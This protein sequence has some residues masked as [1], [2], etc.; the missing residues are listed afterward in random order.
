MN[1]VISLFL[2]RIAERFVALLAGL[3]SSRIE[4]FHAESQA[5]QQSQLED[6]ARSYELAGKTEIAAS[7]RQRAS[8]LNSSNPAAEALNIVQSVTGESLHLPGPQGA[9]QIPTAGFRA[10]PGF[11]Q[12]AT[13]KKTKRS[14]A[15]D[16]KK[17]PDATGDLL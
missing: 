9:G 17:S 6:L 13:S 12:N 5:E 16:L 2:D 7:L 15:G 8:G 3:V 1:R 11:D 4:G 10:L 14:R